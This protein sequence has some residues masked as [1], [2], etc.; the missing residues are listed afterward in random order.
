MLER[1]GWAAILVADRAFGRKELLVALVRERRDVVIRV[2][3]DFTVFTAAQPDG[4]LLADVLATLPVVGEVVWDR[5]QEGTLRCEA[6]AATATIRFSRSGRQHDYPEATMQFIEL[7]PLDG[8]TDPLVLATTLP[9]ETL[10]D[11]RTSRGRSAC[12]RGGGPSRP[13][14]RR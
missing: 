10:A 4:A 13:P 7:L 6:R 8:V 11:L 5:G 9:A 12:T 2:D 1:L 14:S 3:A